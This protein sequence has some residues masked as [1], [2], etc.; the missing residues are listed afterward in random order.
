M[1]RYVVGAWYDN[2]RGLNL[3]AEYGHMKSRVN[4]ADVVKE[5][6]AYVLPA[7][8]GASSSRSF[9]GTCTKIR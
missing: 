4:K 6:G 1:T 9:A 2:P 5:N 3:R 7:G 8:T